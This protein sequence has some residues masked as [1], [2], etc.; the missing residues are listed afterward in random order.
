MKDYCMESMK[1]SLFLFLYSLHYIEKVSK[2]G[3]VFF[4]NHM[5]YLVSG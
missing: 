4:Y 1:K 2:Q 5:L 3:Q